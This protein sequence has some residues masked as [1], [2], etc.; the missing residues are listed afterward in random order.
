MKI[1]SYG[2]MVEQL[3]AARQR[4]LGQP[5]GQGVPSFA[6]L[7]ASR[8]PQQ[9]TIGS[10]SPAAPASTATSG[11]SQPANTSAT[12]TVPGQSPV[13]VTQTEQPHRHHRHH[14][15]GMTSLLGG[16]STGAVVGG[17][18]GGVD[19]DETGASGLFASVEAVVKQA[20]GAYRNGHAP[21]APQGTS[22]SAS[23]PTA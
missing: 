23:T 20:I 1:Q 19:A 7:I 16:S 6:A 5:G 12:A 9:G 17:E 14:G 8:Q 15:G 3:G 13:G 21:A 18:G 11:A 22:T 2:S 4:W 10:A